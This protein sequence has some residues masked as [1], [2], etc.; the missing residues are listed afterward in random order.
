[1]LWTK[2][3]LLMIKVNCSR[4]FFGLK[5]KKYLLLEVQISW[6][7]NLANCHYCI[8]KD[9]HKISLETYLFL[10]KNLSNFVSLSWK[11]HNRFCHTSRSGFGSGVAR[12]FP[13]PLPFPEII[14]N[15]SK[16]LGVWHD[17]KWR[18][19][20]HFELTDAQISFCINL[21]KIKKKKM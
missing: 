20:A 11:L 5:T 13:F 2:N 9:M 7:S 18:F 4:Y 14:S 8:L 12:R 6:F 15:S 19:R 17:R 3:V 10:A 16:S 1:M 21:P